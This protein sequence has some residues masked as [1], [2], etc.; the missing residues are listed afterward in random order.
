MTLDMNAWFPEARPSR[1]GAANAQYRDR[2]AKDNVV[3]LALPCSYGMY[4]SHHIK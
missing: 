3:V 1:Q 4:A 2:A